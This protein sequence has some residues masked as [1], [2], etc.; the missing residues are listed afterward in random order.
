MVTL[1][2]PSGT[3]SMVTSETLLMIT[4]GTLQMV[5]TPPL[6]W[7][8]EGIYT[9]PWARPLGLWPASARGIVQFLA[10]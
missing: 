5:S 10:P 4:S 8:G 2:V 1:L 7:S 3:L 6:M 9:T